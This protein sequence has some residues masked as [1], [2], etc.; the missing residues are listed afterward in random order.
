MRLMNKEFNCAEQFMM[1]T[2]AITFND[3]DAAK[4]IMQTASPRTQ[5]ELGRSVKNFSVDH[6]NA[7]CQNVVKQ[8]NRAKFDQNPHLKAYLIGI[9]DDEIVEASPYDRIWGIGF[10]ESRAEKNI[11]KWGYNWLG[12]ILTD[13]R[14]SYIKDTV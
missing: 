4:R 1:Y 13:L 11:G 7:V 6:W 3:L 12:K 9:E 10:D 14:D 8:G 5:K 2:K